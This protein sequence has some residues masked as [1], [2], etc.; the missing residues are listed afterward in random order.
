[1]LFYVIVEP[2]G[3]APDMVGGAVNLALN[4]LKLG[5]VLAMLG[6]VEAASFSALPNGASKR[7]QPCG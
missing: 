2:I 5:G 6:G 3:D 1:V 7:E 4:A